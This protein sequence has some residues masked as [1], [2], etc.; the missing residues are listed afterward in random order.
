MMFRPLFAKT[1]FGLLAAAAVT[2]VALPE[3]ASACHRRGSCHGGCY[4]GGCHGGG[5]NGGCWGGGG[6]GHAFAGTYRNGYVYYGAPYNGGPA[7]VQG[8]VERRSSFYAPNGEQPNGTLTES[9]GIQNST[10]LPQINGRADFE[11]SAPAGAEIWID[12]TNMGASRSF[13]LPRQITPADGSFNYT[14][15]ATW[16]ENGRQVTKTKPITVRPN[17]KQVIDLAAEQPVK[18]ERGDLTPKSEFKHHEDA[19]PITPA[20]AKPQ[21]TEPKVN[22]PLP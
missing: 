19:K 7:Y 15:K 18:S 1:T 22:K 4:G 5:C 11:V 21:T 13:I 6:G 2:L 14:L 12:N 9:N 20:P 3:S 17:Q 10:Y 16:M 8:D